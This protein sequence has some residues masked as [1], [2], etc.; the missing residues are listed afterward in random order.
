[1]FALNYRHLDDIWSRI[2]EWEGSGAMRI[3]LRRDPPRMR[4]VQFVVQ[5]VD[6]HIG[7]FESPF[8]AG[9]MR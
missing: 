1:M 2:L 9:V 5:L 6:L 3:G 7:F 8:P 4:L